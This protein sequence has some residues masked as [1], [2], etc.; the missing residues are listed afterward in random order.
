MVWTQD[1]DY[2]IDHSFTLLCPTAEQ[3]KWLFIS[4]SEEEMMRVV[5]IV[6]K[7]TNTLLKNKPFYNGMYHR[8]SRK[9]QLALTLLFQ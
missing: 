3:K 8:S 2:S 6:D 7:A 4:E 1:G 5:S 9:Q